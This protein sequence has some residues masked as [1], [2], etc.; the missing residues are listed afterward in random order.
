M[1][2]FR[3]VPAESLV[4]WR[5]DLSADDTLELE[6]NLNCLSFD[7]KGSLSPAVELFRVF[8]HVS[9][10]WPPAYCCPTAASR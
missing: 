3:D 10:G 8:F 6:H 7:R 5:V 2:I 1:H 4:L 9:S